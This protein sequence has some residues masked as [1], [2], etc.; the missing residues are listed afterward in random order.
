[1]PDIRTFTAP[2]R[3]AGALINCNAA[4]LSYEDCAAVRDCVEALIERH[5]N[6]VCFDRE[7]IGASCRG[8]EDYG[9]GWGPWSRYSIHHTLPARAKG[10]Q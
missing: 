6:D 8:S 7:D 3:W 2:T 4:T 1:M 10:A 9:T 5:G